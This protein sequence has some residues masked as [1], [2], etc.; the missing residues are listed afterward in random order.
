MTR[1]SI[2]R[3]SRSFEIFEFIHPLM[4]V[5]KEKEGQIFES[6]Y[7]RRR[8]CELFCKVV[9]PKD[10]ATMANIVDMQAAGSRI[11][12]STKT[13]ISKMHTRGIS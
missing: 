9:L 13:P 10:K 5:R 3:T 2:E 1:C 4:I 12:T 6:R 8:S 11:L 7:V